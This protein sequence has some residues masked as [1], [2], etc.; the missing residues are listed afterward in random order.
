VR[1]RGEKEKKENALNRHEGQTCREQQHKR[2]GKRKD[3]GGGQGGAEQ[4]AGGV[5]SV[6]NP[7]SK[8]FVPEHRGSGMSRS[9]ESLPPGSGTVRRREHIAKSKGKPGG[10]RGGAAIAT[11]F[12]RCKVMNHV[13][14]PLS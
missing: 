7:I 6:K 9:R 8:A 12:S 13:Q 4:E 10:R 14:S 3:G 2:G 11:G 1:N 5:L